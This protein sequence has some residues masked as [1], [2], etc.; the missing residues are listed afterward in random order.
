MKQILVFLTLVWTCLSP[1][2]AW[3]DGVEK[4]F[5][6]Y[7]ELLRD[8][9]RAE[10]KTNYTTAELI[11]LLPVLKEQGY[12]VIVL[13]SFQLADDKLMDPSNGSEAAQKVQKN[14]KAIADA[15]ACRK[16]SIIPE[17]MAVG[18]SESILQNDKNLAVSLRGQNRP[19]M[20]GL[21]P[22]TEGIGYVE[23]FQHGRCWESSACPISCQWQRFNQSRH[24][25]APVIR[26]G[27]LLGYWALIEVRSTIT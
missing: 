26:I 8:P 12:S 7:V 3:A 5:Y 6:A 16:M 1:G 9:V 10:D 18:G 4:W 20:C 2:L 27:K 19:R 21:K 23:Q 22:A 15:V 25:T 17:V 14:L 24:C 11:A 13:S